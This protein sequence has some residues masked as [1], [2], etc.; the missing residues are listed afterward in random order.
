MSA[1]ELQR[2]SEL[3]AAQDK[4]R[5]LFDDILAVGLIA[6]G[7][8]ESAIE[9][10]I[11][12]LARS[13]YGVKRHWHKRVIRSGPNTMTVYREEPPDLTIA[14]DDIVYVDLGPVFGEW[15][16]DFGR[17]FVVGDDPAKLKLRDDLPEMFKIGRAHFENNDALTGAELFDFM[18][19]QAAERGWTF[20]GEIAGHIVGEFPHTKIPGAESSFVIAPQNPGRLRDL[21][22]NGNIRHWILEVHL[23]DPNRGFGGFYEEL[24]TV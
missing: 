6:P 9:R 21:D 16:A 2:E 18:G 12:E 24:M 4:A 5:A 14:A 17:T 11:F 20:G 7:K 8:T 13:K 22:E 19:Q 1:I 3:R 23:I 10:D 15:E